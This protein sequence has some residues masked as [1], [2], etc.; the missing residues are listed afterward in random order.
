MIIALVTIILLGGGVAQFNVFSKDAQKQILSVVEDQEQARK[1]K[2]LMKSGAKEA[3]KFSKELASVLKAWLKEDRDPAAGRDEFDRSLAKA[4]LI[5][6]AA[7]ASFLD[8]AFEIKDAVT[9]K[10]WDA[11]FERAPGDE[12]ID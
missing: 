9:A 7:Q 8:S 11:A 10:Q 5:R 6:S 4:Q 1:V 2:W 3:K 12:P